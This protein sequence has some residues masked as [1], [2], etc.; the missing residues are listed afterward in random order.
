MSCS[1]WAINCRHLSKIQLEKWG[2]KVQKM[3]EE[4]ALFRMSPIKSETFHASLAW[5]SKLSI[6]FESKGQF[7]EEVDL[8]RN[9]GMSKLNTSVP[10]CKHL[11]VF[12]SNQDELHCHFQEFNQCKKLHSPTR[13]F[14]LNS[15]LFGL[16]RDL[17]RP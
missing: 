5:K 8:T 17:K 6:K 3:I 9:F 13:W 12:R 15:N 7:V 10:P 11:F 4:I 2:A 1:D 16:E 14:D